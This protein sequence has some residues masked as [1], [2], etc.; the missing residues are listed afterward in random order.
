MANFPSLFS[1]LLLLLMLQHSAA[2]LVQQQ[3][4]VLE[5]HRD[6]LLEGNHTVNLLFYGRL[7]P[8]QRSIVADFVPS[9]SPAYPSLPPPSAASWWHTTSLY[10]GG[11]PVR[12]YLGP[13]ILDEGYTRGK[14][15]N[16][17]HQM[18]KS[19]QAP[20]QYRKEDL[21]PP[22]PLKAL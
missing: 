14:S 16:N 19:R 8:S 4:L 6:R 5:N 7:S 3:P 18:E 1:H 15:S 12:L 20:S 21:S 11:G 22:S 2:V 17:P 13:Q 10:G 9:L